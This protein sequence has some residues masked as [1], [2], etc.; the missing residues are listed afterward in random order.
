MTKIKE[1]K[2][3]I[4]RPLIRLLL[5]IFFLALITFAVLTWV[6]G[7]HRMMGNNMFPSIKDGD[8]CVMYK[9]EEYH[10]DDIVAYTDN[11]GASKI[12]RIVA[13]GGQKVEFP[14]E[15]GYTVDGYQPSEEITY[16]T[17]G[18]DDAPIEVAEGSFFILN[19]F[20]SD[21]DDSRIY[22]PIE[23]DRIDGKLMFLLRRRGF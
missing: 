20:R 21:T 14:K 22:G 23:E 4:V 5:K 8:L 10:A 16:E 11:S 12:G 9:L 13:V 7:F 17:H 6:L 3:S 18:V 15:G 19:D 1:K 2:R